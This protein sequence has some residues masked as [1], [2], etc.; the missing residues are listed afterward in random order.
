MIPLRPPRPILPVKPRRTMDESLLDGRDSASLKGNEDALGKVSPLVVNPATVAPMDTA[1]PVM[2]ATP[3]PVSPATVP[4]NKDG[5][6]MGATGKVSPKQGPDALDRALSGGLKALGTSIGAREPAATPQPSSVAPIPVTPPLAIPDLGPDE[7]NLLGQR[8]RAA[9]AMPPYAPF[10]GYRRHGG[11]VKPG[12]VYTVG[13]AGPEQVVFDQP[14]TVVPNPDTPPVQYPVVPALAPVTD[15]TGDSPAVINPS[16]YQPPTSG[17]TQELSGP[18]PV[19]PA[20]SLN[21]DQSDDSHFDPRAERADLS[22]LPTA[23]APP[24]PPIPAG[25]KAGSNGMSV[26]LTQLEKIQAD[27]NDR[28]NRD[29]HGRQDAE[30]PYRTKGRSLGNTLK[31]MGIGFLQAFN[32]AQGLPLGQRLVYALGA[33]AGGGVAGTVDPNYSREQMNQHKLAELYQQYGRQSAMDD[34]ETNRAYKVAQTQAL[35]QK[36]VNDANRIDGQNLRSV[37]RDLIQQY[38]HLPAFD[39]TDPDN[40][41]FVSAARQAG[42]TLPPKDA[43]SSIK[44]I[45]DQKTGE[46]LRGCIR[47]Y[48]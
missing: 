32:Q 48:W 35:I 44:Y 2:A 27:I 43:K 20:T 9:R 30:H 45:T 23:L 12:E 1:P 22:N 17:A 18:V 39:P 34:A 21:T 15:D 5:L 6:E 25:Y 13:E 37:R 4:T 16:A 10:G 46:N 8:L 42:L 38:N 28:A 47:R 31:G 14:G 3:M 11:R 33:G 29:Y 7:M 41:D 26:P 36:P 24:T 19:N 40:A